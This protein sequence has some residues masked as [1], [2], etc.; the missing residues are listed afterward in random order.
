V[1]LEQKEHAVDDQEEAE[2]TGES[3]G[4]QCLEQPKPDR[5]ADE[6]ASDVG[7][8]S[9]ASAVPRSTTSFLN[10]RIREIDR[11]GVG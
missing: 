1:G 3:A 6:T 5:R 4:R 10:E 11:G 7:E 9:F 8:C 2:P